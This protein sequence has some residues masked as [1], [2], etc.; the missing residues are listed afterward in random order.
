MIP[1]ASEGVQ[2]LSGRVLGHVLPELSSKYVMSDTAMLGMLMSA[3]AEELESG[4]AKRLV[5]IDA[6]EQLL[7]EAVSCGFGAREPVQFLPGEQTLSRVNAVHDELTRDL[8]ELHEKVES[9]TEYEALNKSI[10][11]YLSAHSERH[12]LSI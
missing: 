12:A 1:K 8:I 7:Q 4:I 2:M 10:W 5:D 9:A 3:L 11:A 6:M